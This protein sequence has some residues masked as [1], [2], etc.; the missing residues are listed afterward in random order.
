M[1]GHMEKDGFHPHTEYKGVRKSRDQQAKTEG[2]IIRKQRDTVPS[3]LS[4]FENLKLVKDKQT[5]DNMIYILRELQRL[6]IKNDMD[7]G[8][9][10][11]FLKDT[12][13]GQI[14][15]SLDKKPDHYVN[16]LGDFYIDDRVPF[17]GKKEVRQLV[18]QDLRNE[19]K[20]I[21][22]YDKPKYVVGDIVTPEKASSNVAVGRAVEEKPDVT[23]KI[24][25][26]ERELDPHYIG[27]Q[28]VDVDEKPFKKNWIYAGSD[29]F[30]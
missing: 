20:K 1:K 27:Y 24:M 5:R 18:H 17:R 29:N 9:I 15:I 23:F 3:D 16:S 6:F 19:M 4:G 11:G 26:M 28:I 13:N 22:K 30:L 2:V 7:G 25:E 21:V 12:V 8:M 14:L 10:W